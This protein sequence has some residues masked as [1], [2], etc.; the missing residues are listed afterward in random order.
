[1]K[2]KGE[3]A[4]TTIGRELYRGKRES[5]GEEYA[6][7]GQAGEERQRPTLSTTKYVGFDGWKGDEEE[8]RS[9]LPEEE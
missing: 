8:K 2:G 3:E 5:K 7:K 9:P 1:M 6:N 4:A